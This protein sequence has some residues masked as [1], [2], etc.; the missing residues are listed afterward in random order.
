VSSTT[1]DYC[2][3]RNLPFAYL[4]Y[5]GGKS[6][7]NVMDRFWDRAVAKGKDA[8]P[9]RATFLQLVGVAET[10]S[11]AEEQYAKHVEYFYHKLLH[12]PTYQIAPPGY[13]DYKSLLNLLVSGKDFLQYADLSIDLK[14]LSAKDMIENEFVVVGSPA[15]VREKLESMAKRLNVGHLMVALQF[16]S[17]PHGQ[18]KSNIDL[19]GRNV[20]PHLQNIWEDKKWDNPWWPKRLRN[21]SPEHRELATA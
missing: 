19:F 20:L 2:H 10:D 5:F 12:Q 6:A 1:W 14:P 11:Q 4:S 18:A 9:Y 21:R 8:N 3:D 7:N 15:T 16:G 13:A 17:M